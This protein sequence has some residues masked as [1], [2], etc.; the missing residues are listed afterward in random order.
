MTLAGGHLAGPD[1]GRPR[2]RSPAPPL[3]SQACCSLVPALFLTRASHTALAH[4]TFQLPAI[5]RSLPRPHPVFSSLQP[6]TVASAG[7]PH[8]ALPVQHAGRLSL[9][10]LPSPARHLRL[11]RRLGLVR[12]MAITG[13]G[14]GLTPPRSLALPRR[15][16]ACCSPGPAQTFTRTPHTGRMPWPTRPHGC[17]QPLDHFN[18]PHLVLFPLHPL[19]GHRGHNGMVSSRTLALEVPARHL[20]PLH[21]PRSRSRS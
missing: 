3:R 17:R 21:S 7:P 18:R 10:P 6:S 15:S 5:N 20:T 14:L 1:L 11:L 19:S 9:L 16:P 2:T 13:P 12:P 8:G 4:H